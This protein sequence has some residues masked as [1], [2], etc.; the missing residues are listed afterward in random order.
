MG[1]RDMSRGCKRTKIGRRRLARGIA[2]AVGAAAVAMIAPVDAGAQTEPPGVAPPDAQL[3]DFDVSS[4]AGVIDFTFSYPNLVLPYRVTGGVLEALTGASG[5]GNASGIAGPM[6]VPAA[7]TLG[8]LFPGN[9]PTTDIPTPEEGRR[10]WGSIDWHALPNYCKS[11]YPDYL[12]EHRDER[13]C[14]GPAAEDARLGF[15]AAL[16]NGKT[17]SSGTP[18]DPLRASSAATSR[19]LD[20]VIPSMQT[21]IHQAWSNSTSGLNRDGVPEG[22]GVVEIDEVSYLNGL[23][24]L[25]GVRSEAIA[26]SDGTKVGTKVTTSFSVEDA[27]VAGVPV[28]ISR[29]GV[30][31]KEEKLLPGTSVQEAADQISKALR[32]ADVQ[33][34]LAPPPLSD[35]QGTQAIAQSEGVEIVHQGGTL[36]AANSIYRFGFASANAAASRSGG[37]TTE[38]PGAGDLG[39]RGGPNS[40]GE[41]TSAGSSPHSEQAVRDDSTMGGALRDATA[42]SPVGQDHAVGSSYGEGSEAPFQALPSAVGSAAGTVSSE[43]GEGAGVPAGSASREV[44]AGVAGPPSVRLAPA[45]GAVSAGRALVPS[46]LKRMAGVLLLLAV[47]GAALPIRR[48]IS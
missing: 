26:V 19:G 33:I 24:R 5:T 44:A 48:A 42:S 27:T 34:R 28:V 4:V 15:T 20:V 18:V 10:G 25:S 12:G 23:V 40:A 30:S 14:G 43:G 45:V 36:T 2:A 16:A 38:A 7:V 11:E 47:L 35:V 8:Q 13:Y 46:G 37:G 22:R 31:V 21:T 32:A 17:K 39:G 3:A 6:P 9:V 29:D 1:G 41:G